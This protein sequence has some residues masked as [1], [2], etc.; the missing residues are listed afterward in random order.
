MLNFKVYLYKAMLYKPFKLNV[1][2]S[3]GIG[4]RAGLRNQC[5]K[6]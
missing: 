4:I 1:W 6:A 3:G 5:R 2:A